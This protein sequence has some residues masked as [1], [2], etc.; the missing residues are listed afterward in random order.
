MSGRIKARPRQG[1]EV[2]MAG[3]TLRDYEE[4]ERRRYHDNLRRELIERGSIV[5]TTPVE[6]LLKD[7]A[8]RLIAKGWKVTERSEEDER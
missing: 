7:A 8:P 4:V 5:D 2:D 6:E 1:R 3:K